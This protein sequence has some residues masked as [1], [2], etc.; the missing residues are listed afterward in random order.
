MKGLVL[1]QMGK[2]DEGT[3]MV[4]N[5]IKHDLTSHIVWH[6]FGLV[7]K[8]EKNYEEALKSYTQALKFDKDNINILRDAANLQTQLRQ[9]EGLVETRHTILRYRPQLRQHWVG[10]AVAY[11]LAGNI[12]DARK[13]MA[14]Y[15]NTVKVRGC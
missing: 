5:G 6:V 13:T 12:P 11:H 8:A 7:Q 15:L 1:T 4:K 3:A 10:L 2:R 9:Y 14:H